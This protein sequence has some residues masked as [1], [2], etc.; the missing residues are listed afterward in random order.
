MKKTVLENNVYY[1]VAWS[2]MRMYDKHAASR[3]LPELAGIVCL[4]R[5]Q[6]KE[7]H[8]YLMFL[9]CWR[10]GLRLSLKNF[11]DPLFSKY[12]DIA[13]RLES[14]KVLYKFT[15]VDTSPSDMQDAMYGLIRT[16]QPEYNN[17]GEFQDSKRYKNI[18]VKE[19]EMGKE[20]II[21]KF[22]MFGL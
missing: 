12:K 1:T 19:I 2:P 6:K 11:M 7:E 21:E 5:E 17:I 13:T 14:E 16:Y 9:A 10:N 22:P 18:F 3:I 20:D 8:D 4:L 15:V